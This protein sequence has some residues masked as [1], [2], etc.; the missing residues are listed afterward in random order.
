MRVNTSRAGEGA[1]ERADRNVSTIPYGKPGD[2]NLSSAEL[3]IHN[4]EAGKI[5]SFKAII[6]RLGG[7]MFKH[8]GST[9][10]EFRDGSVIGSTGVGR[11]YKYWL[12]K[13]TNERI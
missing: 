9:Y 3:T 12:E 4:Y 11:H 6:T 10:F 2:K 5:S 13:K 1:Q 7:R 8:N